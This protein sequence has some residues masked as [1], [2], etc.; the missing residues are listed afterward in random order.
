MYKYF[1][2]APLSRIFRWC[3]FI[4]SLRAATASNYFYLSIFYHWS[5]LKL[6]GY[7]SICSPFAPI[8]K[9]SLLITSLVAA[10]TLF[11]LL[12][13]IWNASCILAQVSSSESMF[14]VRYTWF[15]IKP[16]KKN[17]LGSNPVN[18][19][20]KVWVHTTQS[21]VLDTDHSRNLELVQL[22]GKVLHRF[23]ST[24]SSSHREVHLPAA[25]WVRAWENLHRPLHKPF[26]VIW[27]K[28]EISYT[29]SVNSDCFVKFPFF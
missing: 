2:S 11:R 26:R 12:L 29:H 5:K 1:T 24:S 15:L 23:D 3:E 4:P 16:H 22:R 9:F 21:N 20:A 18:V 13:S 8:V 10:P 17:Q 28:P 7:C 27:D 25:P 14:A 6:L 19:L